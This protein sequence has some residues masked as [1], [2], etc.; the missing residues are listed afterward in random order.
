MA[1]AGTVQIT[2]LMAPT[3]SGDTYPVTDTFYGLDGLRNVG[4]TTERNAIPADRRRAGMMVGLSGGTK[5]YKLR[6]EPWVFDDTDWDELD[7]GLLVPPISFTADT[8][9]SGMTYNN[10]TYDLTVSLNDGSSYTQSLAGLASDVYVLSGVYQ[11]TTGVIEFTNSSGGTFD[12][13][14]FTTGMTNYYTTDGTL[15]GSTIHFDRTD[16][17]DAYEVDLSSLGSVGS[18]L[19]PLI[20]NQTL[21]V[22]N[23]SIQ[24]SFGG[25]VLDSGSI[26]SNI[27]GGNGHIINNSD[28]SV[29]AGGQGNSATTNN[30]IFIGGGISN[31]TNSTS[32]V[33]GGG[34]DNSIV[35]GTVYGQEATIVGGDRNYTY[36]APWSFIGGGQGNNNY[37][38]YGVIGGGRYNELSTGGRSSFIG[39]GENN[40]MTGAT[41]HSSIVGG[42]GNEILQ[43]GGSGARRSSILGGITNLIYGSNNSSIVGGENNVINDGFNN[44][45]G[46]GEGNRVIGGSIHSSVVGGDSNTI[47]F[48]T[49]N[50]ISVMLFL[51]ELDIMVT[52]M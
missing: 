29:I 44:F 34:A 3:F 19:V 37:S 12:V 36:Y 52:V 49:G 18:T 13:A 2:G 24:P 38:Y 7:F 45:V 20:F 16:T 23:T 17:S 31:Y 8:F 50:T 10:G 41:N 11:P 22:P 5:Y 33:V 47:G 39:G 40:V 25:S 42:S 46:G 21:T 6:E 4:T 1:I 14:G 51:V 48:G 28:N 30:G 35:G 9:V 26:Y 15:S 32:S 43:G 27:L